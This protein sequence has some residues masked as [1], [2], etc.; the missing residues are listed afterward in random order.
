MNDNSDDDKGLGRRS[1]IKRAAAAAAVAGTAGSKLSQS[2]TAQP[3]SG[4]MP[5]KELGKTGVKVPILQIGTAGDVD[6]TYDKVMHYCYREGVTMIDTALQYGWGTSHKAV[7]N[8][9]KQIDDRKNLWVTSK[10][11][12]GSISRLRTDLDKCLNDM[13]LDYLDA[14]FMHGVD[15]PKMLE[16]EYI[17]VADELRKTGKTKFFG[18]S[19]HNDNV[20]ELMNKA[21]KVG[22]IDMIL[23][24]YNFRKYGDME[25]NKAIDACKAAG[26]GLM[27]MK[28]QASVPA[29]IENVAKFKSENFTLGQ[30][31]LKSVWADERIDTAVSEMAT[32]R[33]AREN[34]AAAKSTASLNA[35]ELHQLNRLAAMTAHYHCQGCANLCESACDNQFAIAD[36]MRYLMY[37]ESYGKQ[38]RARELYSE[39]PI[40]LKGFDREPLMKA[41]KACPQGIDIPA[42][43]AQA[44]HLL[45]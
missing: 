22:G 39:V 9:I 44:Q 31:K 6:T 19:C 16:P 23:F 21:A 12:S 5:R 17:Q 29:D 1:F 2:A 8:F 24:R 26:I 35:G 33:E 14:Y 41:S 40:K 20:V 10:S 3:A 18:F 34:V 30:A 42:R 37:Y 13:E 4:Q 45:A 11:H 36:T 32:T 38:R 7:G 25:L 28:T 43:L 15:N 27:A